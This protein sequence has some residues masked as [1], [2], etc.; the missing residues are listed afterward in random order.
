MP[1]VTLPV[2]LQDARQR[3]CSQIFENPSSDED[4]EIIFQDGKVN[5][6]SEL[7]KALRVNQASCNK[8]GSSPVNVG[9]KLVSIVPQ[10]A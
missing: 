9:E 1:E 5:F 8:D 3:Y 4:C 7:E 6:D 10:A 2:K